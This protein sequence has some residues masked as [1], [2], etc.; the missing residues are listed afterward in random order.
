[1]A[2]EVLEI[3]VQ[4]PVH[5]GLGWRTIMIMS[6]YGSDYQ[7]A[8]PTGVCSA[9]GEPLEPGSTCIATLCERAEDDSFDRKDFSLEAWSGGAR[10]DGLFS[11]WKLVV[12]A[13]RCQAQ[14]AGG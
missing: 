9:T 3:P 11:Y 13:A 4:R 12:S 10:P 5:L 8:R 14:D 1:M 2:T 6:R 7:V